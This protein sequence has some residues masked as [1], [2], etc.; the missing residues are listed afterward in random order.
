[1]K[2]KKSAAPAQ[3]VQ[4]PSAPDIHESGSAAATAAAVAMEEA[5]R[6][7][8]RGRASTVLASDPLMWARDALGVN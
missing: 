2:K 7:S 3:M 8:T 5:R 6:L 4:N 1:M